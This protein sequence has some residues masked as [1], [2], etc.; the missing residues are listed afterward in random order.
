MQAKHSAPGDAEML[1]QPAA[2]AEIKEA[3]TGKQDLH[4]CPRCGIRVSILACYRWPGH[5][6]A[7]YVMTPGF[8]VHHTLSPEIQ[9]T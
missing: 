3:I 7:G 1:P 4:H 2:R 5:S 9:N 8:P 6:P